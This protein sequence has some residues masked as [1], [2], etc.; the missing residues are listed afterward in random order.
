MSCN[1]NFSSPRGT[2]RG[3]ADD[4]SLLLGLEGQVLWEQVSHRQEWMSAE[5]LGS[6]DEESVMTTEAMQFIGQLRHGDHICLLYENQA[7]H[8]AV[9]APFHR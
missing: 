5:G 3:G 9:I 1:S 4:G 7:E 2:E 6:A 8:L